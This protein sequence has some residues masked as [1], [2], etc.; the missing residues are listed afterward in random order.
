VQLAEQLTSWNPYDQNAS[1]PFFDPEWMFGIKDGF[2]IVSGNPP[3]IT[4]S[5]GKNQNIFTKVE[6]EDYRRRYFDVFE[7]KGN[8]FALFIKI[9]NELLI[10]DGILSYIIPNTLLMNSTFQNLRKYMLNSFNLSLVVN[11]KID[12]FESATTGGNL[13]FVI[14][15]TNIFKPIRF[16]NILENTNLNNIEFSYTNQENFKSND[17]QNFILE[18]E[19]AELESKIKKNKKTL[20]E[21]A[22]LY[23]GIKTGDNKRFISDTCLNSF[24]LPIIRGRDIQKYSINYANMYV[25]FDKKLLWSNTNEEYLR[26]NPKIIIR[27][28]GE[29][30]TAALDNFG[31]LTM[32]TTHI[33]FDSIIDIRSLIG[34]LNSK[35][36]NWY[37]QKMVSE[38]NRVFAEVKIVNLKKLPIRITKDATLKKISFLVNEILMNSKDLII[39]SDIEQ[40][41]D[42]L[43][44]RLYD[45][46]Y[47]EVRVIDPE[48]ESKISEE[49]YNLIEIE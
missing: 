30:L 32:D 7:Y 17:N 28:T 20:G 49:D 36:L 1:S 38:I 33:I 47:E 45:L 43:V 10:K 40:Q 3:Y 15:K 31:Y 4:I 44:Y 16:T 21:I 29:N 26:K 19:N 27:Q 42:N 8:T 41:I 25:L 14:K 48:I 24:Y 5:L 23:N 11:F 2:D 9:A 46:T 13:I 34:I 39:K 6:I 35:L 37:Y 22:K 12:V 18:F